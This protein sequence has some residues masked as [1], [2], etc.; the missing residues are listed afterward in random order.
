MLKISFRG[1][2]PKPTP[3]YPPGTRGVVVQIVLS[4]PGRSCAGGFAVA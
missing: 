2:G 1:R 4:I 3:R